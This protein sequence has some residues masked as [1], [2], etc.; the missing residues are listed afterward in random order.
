MRIAGAFLVFWSACAAN[1]YARDIFVSNQAGDDRFDGSSAVTQGS[2]VGPVRTIARALRAAAPGD[3]IVLAATNE[4]YRES[5]TL[6]SA[7]HSGIPDRPFQLLGNGAILDGLAPIPAGAWEHVR[8]DVFRFRPARTSYQLLFLEGRPAV[9]VPSDQTTRRLP[10]LKPKEWCLFDRHIYFCVEPGKLPDAYG[11]Q[12]AFLTVG[13][14]LYEVRNVVIRDLTVQGFQLDGINA[15][16]GV[17]NARL[18]GVTCRGNARSGVSVG[19]ASRV[20]LENCLLGGNGAAQLRTEGFSHTRLLDCRLLDATAPPLVREGGEVLTEKS[21][22]PPDQPA[23]Q[24]TTSRR[25]APAVLSA[26][27]FLFRPSAH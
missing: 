16:D 23:T 13:I 11:L 7:Q 24:S 2:Q 1:G 9:R 14:T 22:P 15:H 20:R 5:I 17:V 27:R 6:Q 10:A 18:S 8:G 26:R 4:P 3:R 12:F 21:S 19:G 25:V